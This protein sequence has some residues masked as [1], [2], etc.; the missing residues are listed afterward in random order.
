LPP[1]LP[2]QG[3]GVVY[4]VSDDTY[5][6]AI[7]GLAGATEQRKTSMQIEVEHTALYITAFAVATAVTLFVIALARGL[8]FTYAIV[9]GFVLVLGA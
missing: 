1:P 4:R 2:L 6:G 7:A 8:G 5:I 3:R 9:Y